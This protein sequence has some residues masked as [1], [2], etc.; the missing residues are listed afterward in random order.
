VL[1]LAGASVKAE[2]TYYFGGTLSANWG[3]LTAGTPFSGSFSYEYPQI[4]NKFPFGDGAFY[5][6]NDFSF[7]IGSE[8][9]NYVSAPTITIWNYNAIWPNDSFKISRLVSGSLGGQA[10]TE[11]VVWLIDS[12]G[13]WF[14]D[15]NLPE[16]FSL[17]ELTPYSGSTGSGFYISGNSITVGNSIT[18]LVPEPSSLSLL[19]AG[20]LVAL[21]RRRKVKEK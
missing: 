6:V 3:T 7:T 5:G 19:L 10:V 12:T 2:V 17:G 13:T 14:P 4:P 18:T 9:L 8:S 11:V 20:G 1:V 15:S 21:A 16:S